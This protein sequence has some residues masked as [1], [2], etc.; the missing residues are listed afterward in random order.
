MLCH[1][2]LAIRVALNPPAGSRR[3]QDGGDVRQARGGTASEARGTFSDSWCARDASD[4][5]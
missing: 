5:V 3:A 1:T 4:A 2:S